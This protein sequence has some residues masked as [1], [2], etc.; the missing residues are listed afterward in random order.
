MCSMAWYIWKTRQIKKLN[1]NILYLK[2][3]YDVLSCFPF[4][5]VSP[6][7]TARFSA[8]P[9]RN[10]RDCFT[11]SVYR[12][13]Q[14]KI[15]QC[16][17]SLRESERETGSHNS[18]VS[19]FNR[20]LCTANTNEHHHHCVY[21]ATLFHFRAWTDGKTKDIIDFIYIYFESW[22]SRLW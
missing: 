19:C 18:G 15:V 2:G 14:S 7:H 4:S 12:L 10:S 11:V 5:C 13:E 8:V 22:S 6:K 16:V 17:W 1:S 3:S 20:G 21:H 9:I